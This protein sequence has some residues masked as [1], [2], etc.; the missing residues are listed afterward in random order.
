MQRSISAIFIAYW[1]DIKSLMRI[2]CLFLTT[3]CGFLSTEAAIDEARFYSAPKRC[4]RWS[5]TLYRLHFF[6]IIK[7]TKITI[8]CF[9]YNKYPLHLF[10]QE[11]YEICKQNQVIP[12]EYN[13]QHRATVWKGKGMQLTLK[14]RY[15]AFAKVK[16]YEPDR[17]PSDEDL[18]ISV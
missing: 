1:K 3:A 12:K 2:I 18:H 10:Y 17:S 13:D 4:V 15:G 5:G 9:A 14:I 7:T 6:K 11:N 16:K 8:N